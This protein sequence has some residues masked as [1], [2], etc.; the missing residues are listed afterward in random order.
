MLEAGILL[1]I[2][3]LHRDS[4]F[5][6]F[7]ANTTSAQLHLKLSN[8]RQGIPDGFTASAAP[9]RQQEHLASALHSKVSANSGSTEMYYEQKHQVLCHVLARCSRQAVDETRP[10]PMTCFR[11]VAHL[12]AASPL[13][14]TKF[15]ITIV[16]TATIAGS[17]HRLAN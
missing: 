15:R 11:L 10:D 3:F 1:D 5:E 7:A 8:A 16:S 14:L 17:A 4:S 6:Y 2:I 9:P 12:I 13:Q